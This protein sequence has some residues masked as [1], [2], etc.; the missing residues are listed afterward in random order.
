MKPE[1]ER[2]YFISLKALLYQQLSCFLSTKKKQILFHFISFS[3]KGIG[4]AS[5][6]KQNKGNFVIYIYKQL[7][8]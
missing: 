5:L 1:S 2:F 6:M 3:K 4:L 8:S 7:L